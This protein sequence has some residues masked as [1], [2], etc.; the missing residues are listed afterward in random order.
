MATVWE[1][2][3]KVL[4]RR[5]AIKVLHPHLAG[6]DG[7]RTRFRREAVAAAKL[8]HPHIVT[9]YDTGRDADVAYIVMEL[10]EGTTLARMLKT[11][12][13]L[14]LAKAVDVAVQV[15]DALACAHSHGVVHR[16]VKPANILLREDGH[17][18]VAD[19][20]IAKAGTGHDLTR[21]GVVMGTAKYLSPEQVSGSPADAGSDIYALGIVLYEMLAGSPPFIGDS[22]LST[23]VA[24]LTA[25]PGSLR[26]RRAD[27]P[28]SLEAV[29]L[30]S[31]ARDPATRFQS[32]DEL[33]A[34]LLAVD[35]DNDEETP[36]A[37]LT[38]TA[39]TPRPKW[40]R[41]RVAAAAVLL[42]ATGMAGVR[43]LGGSG[44]SPADIVGKPELAS[45]AGA[46]PAPAALPASS[47]DPFG[48]DKVE[49]QATVANVSDGDPNTAWKTSS[50]QDQ[51]P[52][53]KE[54]VGVYVDLGRAEKVRRVDVKAT[55]GYTA[56]IFVADRPSVDLAGW[57][58]PRADGGAGTFNV[59][60]VTGRYVLVWFTS[61]P[62][63]DGAYRVEVSDIS[64]DTA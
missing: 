36:P 11:Q 51:F 34:S 8:A 35:S 30:R 27:V 41:L 3:D 5:V 15:A 58:K 56:Q 44:E 37:G 9:T 38:L 25:A 52:R 19:F 18:K 62:Q 40:S 54:G 45:P 4:T 43:A 6:D 64:V 31:L 50:Y 1:A 28:R 53:F 10:V 24:R 48:D 29:V 17:V 57:G 39:A 26:D 14:P 12:G 7:F 42:V 20:G 46:L 63:L 21:T 32:A 47:F 61:L 60:S 13:P 23:A 22:D 55:P 2:E 33:R 16:D 59:G 49:N